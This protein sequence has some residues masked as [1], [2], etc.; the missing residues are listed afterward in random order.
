[1]GA[2]GPNKRRIPTV[3]RNLAIVYFNKMQLPEKA[4]EALERAY[5]LDPSDAR[6]LLEL[7]QLHKKLGWPPARRIALYQEHR[8]VFV[9]RDDLITEY[10]T[11]LNLL[12]RH[13]EAYSIM[14]GHKFHPWEGGE[15]K[16]TSQYVFSL[17][18]LARRALKEGRPK[19]PGRC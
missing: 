19:G 7:D 17:R 12:G 5:R 18:E 10:V 13:E 16:I 9:L 3:W 4:L 11:L 8:E 1:M 6:V 2:R 15:G 14:M